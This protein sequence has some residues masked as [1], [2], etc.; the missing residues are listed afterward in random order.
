MNNGIV[1]LAAITGFALLFVPPLARGAGD[2]E[3]AGTTTAP[4][5]E[6]ASE[7]SAGRGDGFY[8]RPPDGNFALQVGGDIQADG[9]AFLAD[10][11]QGYADQFLLRRAR[12]RLRGTFQRN[13]D[14]VLAA[15][16]AGGKVQLNNTFLEVRFARWARLR[17]GKFVVPV[18]LELLQSADDTAFTERAL[19][20]NLAP[21]FSVGMALLG[22]VGALASYQLAVT[23]VVPDGATVEGDLADTKEVTGRL[24]LYPLRPSG[25]AALA[26]FGVGASASYGAVRGKPTATELPA[27]YKTN[28]QNDFFTYIVT[29]NNVTGKIDP[30]NTVYADGG[31]LRWSAQGYYS[32]GPL[33]L[34]AEYIRSTQRVHKGA[35]VQ[36][37]QN[38]G[39]QATAGL[40][41]TGEN[42]SFKGGVV[43]AR[44]FDTAAGGWGAVEVVARYAVLKVD[45]RLFIAGFA[46]RT[47]SSREAWAWA[48]GAN[49][50]LNRNVR[51]SADFM[52]TTFSQGAVTASGQVADRA[53]ESAV[54]TRVQTVF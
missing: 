35:L 26:G 15:N 43:P 41:L 50:Y 2:T 4:T 40:V 44:A 45:D 51:V 8:A 54:L 9:R 46:D 32:H 28:G 16:L 33:G 38:W 5:A 20:S 49:W 1:S 47:A 30:T 6:R 37:P 21:Y 29:T 11:G 7:P 53:P 48:A 36:N 13:F 10:G 22:E 25:V 24:F 31:H 3:P 17:V 39:W 23:D 14:F 19:P 42:A 52:R 34:Q 18:G 27:S 12:A